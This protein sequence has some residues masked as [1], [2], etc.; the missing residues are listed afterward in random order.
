M[1]N[2][3]TFQLAIL[4]IFVALLL[5]GV[6]IFAGILPGFR[7][8]QGG[9]G[10]EVLMWGTLPRSALADILN[11]FNDQHESE[12][13]VVYQEKDQSV[14]E[15]DFLE[16]KADNRAP[17][18]LLAPHE[19]IIT[20]R[21][22]LVPIP[23]DTYPP[24]TFLDTYPTAGRL[25]LQPEGTLA[26]PLLIDPFVLYYNRDLL[27]NAGLPTIPKTWTE[28]I[29]QTAPLT[30]FDGRRNILQSTIALGDYRNIGHMKD[31][32]A[33]L[34]LQAGNPI[35]DLTATRPVSLLNDALGF[36][37]KPA[38]AVL[39][40]YSQFADPARPNY[41]WNR[42]LPEAKQSFTR[43]QSAFYLGPA[44][45]FTEISRANPH[46]VFD[47]ALP[48]QKDNA[49]R[50]TFSRTIG[51][52]VVRDRPKTAV[53]WAAAQALASQATIGRLASIT[54]L[55]PARSDL[56]AVGTTDPIQTVF[57]QAAIIGRNWF[58][59]A[60]P[61]TEAIFKQMVD[62]VLTGRLPSVQ[63]V[64]QANTALEDLINDVYGQ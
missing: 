13:S 62:N 29:G 39:D 50:L 61:R 5:I 49:N 23:A 28:F 31:I 40:F 45:E 42:S 21:D 37:L 44:S 26:L 51:L 58:D 2:L 17:D 6:L 18:L 33:M 16:A 43:G 63:A 52:S 27:T 12:F 48:P 24:R 14:I 7:A 64:S 53:A 1:K 3:S 15:R 4:I 10:G 11:D 57:Y 60:P 9:T 55:P 19:I 34:M 36:T 38:A 59:F 56:L 8:P 22:R 35:L 54:L 30:V 20:Q 25:F 47:V 46:L 41:S 32:L